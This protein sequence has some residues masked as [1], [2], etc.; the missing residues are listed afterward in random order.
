MLVGPYACPSYV[1]KQATDKEVLKINT[2][3]NTKLIAQVAIAESS[4]L[5]KY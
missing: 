1:A 5:E 3:S 4:T 2:R